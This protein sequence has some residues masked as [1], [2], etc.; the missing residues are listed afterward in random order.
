MLDYA[1]LAALAAVVREGSFEKAAT[2]LGVTPSAI[3]QRVRGLEERLGAVLVVRG[4]PC[5]PTGPG[6]RLC[7]HLRQVSLLEDEL[8]SGMPNLGEGRERMTLRVAVNSDSLASWFP[9]AVTRFAGESDALLDLLLDDEEHTAGRLRAGEV[10][11]AVTTDPTPVQGCRTTPLG[12]LPYVA[13]AS[14][15]FV[16]RY[17]PGGIT[18]AALAQA[19]ILRFDRRDALQARWAEAVAGVTLEAPTHWVPSTEGMLNVSLAG[20]GWAMAPLATAKSHLTD[21]TLVE[22]VPGR[23]IEVPL[24]WQHLRLGAKVLDVLTASVRQAAAARLLPMPC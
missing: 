4:Q 16:T 24:Y 22:L 18:T 20:L 6:A 21:G 23:R 13:A 12:M 11:A 10:L 7:A 15:A 19:P 8:A 1:A 17:F 3:S 2:A 5:L 14:P 9:A